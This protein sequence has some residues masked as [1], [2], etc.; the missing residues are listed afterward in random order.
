MN[1][2]VFIFSLNNGGSS[3]FNTSGRLTF[4]SIGEAINLATL[5][6]RVSALYT[7]I[8]AAI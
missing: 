1:A 8:G 7:A 4:Y 5:D 3:S 2:N 6:T